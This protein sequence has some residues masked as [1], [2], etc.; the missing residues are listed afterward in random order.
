MDEKNSSKE[1]QLREVGL[2]RTA[3]R[4]AV[5]EVLQ[6][7]RKEGEKHLSA[8][9]IYQ[10]LHADNSRIG[11]ATI[12]RVLAQFEFAGLAER[13]HFEGQT[14]VY[15]IAEDDHHDHIVCKDCGKVQEFCDPQIE[16]LQVEVARKMGFEIT[17]HTMNL[18]GQCMDP[19]C[20]NKKGKAKPS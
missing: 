15:E 2:R 17:D 6:A 18:F 3:P 8:E 14:S 10:R 5:L 13:H 4:E 7:A 1:E 16:R 12:Y 11:L 19:N 9:D 20:E